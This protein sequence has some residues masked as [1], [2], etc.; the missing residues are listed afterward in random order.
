MTL[1]DGPVPVDPKS[2]RSAFPHRDADVI[3]PGATRRPL[4]PVE[5]G[6]IFAQGRIR[7]TRIRL[8]YKL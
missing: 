7:L 6:E 1:N 2:G 5:Y 8:Q 3:V 4:E